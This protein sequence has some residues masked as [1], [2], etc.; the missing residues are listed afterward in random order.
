M[1]TLSTWIQDASGQPQVNIKALQFRSSIQ[2]PLQTV[3]PCAK[4][5]K[6]VHGTSMNQTTRRGRQKDHL[7]GFVLVGEISYDFHSIKEMT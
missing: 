4:G 2:V 1:K 5:L 7:R 6:N 3:M